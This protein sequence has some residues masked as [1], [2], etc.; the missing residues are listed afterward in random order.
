MK[1][2]RDNVNNALNE[3]Q[4]NL[5]PLKARVTV[6][7]DRISDLEDKPIEKSDEEK[8]GTNSLEGLKTELGK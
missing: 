5:N 6:A 4:S 3:F 8:P 2:T 1:A 7:E